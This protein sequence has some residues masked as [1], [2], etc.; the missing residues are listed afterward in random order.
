MSVPEEDKAVDKARSVVKRRPIMKSLAS[1]GA[2]GFLSQSAIAEK[3][4]SDIDTE[5]TELTQ[6][7][8]TKPTIAMF[9]GPT[10]T[11]LNSG[12]RVTSNK[13]REK[14]DLP[15][16]TDQDGQK[17]G[18]GP[19]APQRLAASVTVYID[20]HSSHPLDSQHQDLYADPD[21]Y[22]DPDTGEFSETEYPG[23]TPVY[24]VTLDP[25]DGLYQLPYMARKRTGEPWES[26]SLNPDSPTKE[27]SRIPFFPDTSRLVE[28]ID[29]FGRN[30]G[31]TNILSSKAD[32]HHYRAAP[33]AGY[34][35]GLPEEERT[36]E[37]E[38]DIPPETWGEDFF[39]YAPIAEDP[40]R[41]TLA[42]ITNSVQNAMDSGD[43]AGA[44]W[45]EGSPTIEETNYWLNLLI[46]TEKPIAANA[47][48]Q[49]HG[50][51]GNR[52]DRNILDSV[53]YITSEIWEDNEG[54]DQ[55]GAV[56]IQEEQIFTSRNVQKR[57]DRAGGY[58][59]TG[60]HGGGI[61][62]STSPPMLTSIP[63]KRHTWN[64]EVNLSNL[65]QT[66]TGVRASSPSANNIETVEI[67]I[68]T[69]AGDLL[70]AIPDV[71]IVKPGEY[72]SD[73]LPNDGN[74]D[75]II[76]EKI[77]Q[78][79][80][81]E[82]LAGF[83]LEGTAPYGSVHES[84]MIALRQAA[85]RG[86]PVVTVGRASSGGFTQVSAGNLLIEG[87]NLVATKARLLLMAS[88]MKFGSLP[89]PQ[90]PQNPTEQ[91]L[92]E[93]RTAVSQYQEIFLTH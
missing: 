16:I 55:I 36:D 63:N 22:V 49:G 93:I 37:G 90:N 31:S 56:N 68:K 28:E 69:S 50:D 2:A 42:E 78:K 91:E 67:G 27:G 12:T 85:L 53:N 10:A 25:E 6:A 59:A 47:S 38:G 30:Y 17:L 51:V 62:G 46:D 5:D 14:Y 88:L 52:G 61:V 92:E 75:T 86:Y 35:D 74:P 81:S 44:I 7:Q 19:L 20:A 89:L 4:I 80:T 82:P 13:A 72:E 39:S 79:L 34:R 8:S 71:S 18:S 76:M 87:G 32:F 43:Y 15:M 66:V 23:D 84:V 41:M 40:T 3:N 70:P 64:S 54:R 26:D 29:R 45:T 48:Q 83:V 21:G 24:E 58:E 9:A 57:D 73:S 11:I 33:S 65:P 77:Q 60:G 1:V